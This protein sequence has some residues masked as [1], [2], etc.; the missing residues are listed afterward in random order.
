MKV[1]TL[2]ALKA[3]RREF[4]DPVIANHHGRVVKTTGVNSPRGFCRRKQNLAGDSYK[5]SP[6]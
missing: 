1:D 4:A 3:I 6:T 5:R 2:R